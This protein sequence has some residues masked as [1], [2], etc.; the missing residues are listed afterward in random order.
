M[1]K[2]YQAA[3]M[4]RSALLWNIPQRVAIIPCRVVKEL[5]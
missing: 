1:Q 3:T 2:Y 5:R 4:L